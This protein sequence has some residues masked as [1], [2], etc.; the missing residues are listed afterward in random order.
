MGVGCGGGALVAI[1]AGR[2]VSLT[3]GIAKISVIHK[4]PQS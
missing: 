1:L 4:A 3:K 2:L